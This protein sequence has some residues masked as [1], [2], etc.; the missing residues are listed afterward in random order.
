MFGKMLEKP[1]ERYCCIGF[2]VVYYKHKMEGALIMEIALSEFKINVG[3]YMDLADT[4]DVIITKH[5]KP[6]AKITR[7]D[8]EPWY[9]RELPETITSVD[10][11][12]GTLPNNIDLDEARMERLTK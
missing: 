5:G 8:K 10:V 6:T 4:E 9:A 11:L 2:F 12:F 3:K 1:P 7:Y